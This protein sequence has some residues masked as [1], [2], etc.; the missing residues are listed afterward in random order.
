MWLLASGWMH[1]TELGGLEPA[2]TQ[3]G[4]NIA[5][6]EKQLCMCSAAGWGFLDSTSGGGTIGL[7]ISHAGDS[8]NATSLL[9][10]HG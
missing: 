6:L 7:I 2:Q 4:C 8:H 9:L 1:G 3:G 5:A 10:S